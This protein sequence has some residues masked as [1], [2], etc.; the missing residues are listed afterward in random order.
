MAYDFYYAET[1]GQWK[2]LCKQVDARYLSTAQ[3]GGFTGS[4]IGLYAVKQK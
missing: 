2:S 3:A 4:T 1:E